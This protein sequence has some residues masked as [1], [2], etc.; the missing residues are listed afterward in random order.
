M[1]NSREDY[2]SG[3]NGVELPYEGRFVLLS[4]GRARSGEGNQRGREAVGREGRK[5]WGERRARLI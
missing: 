5:Q 4:P 1:I 2:V 3:I